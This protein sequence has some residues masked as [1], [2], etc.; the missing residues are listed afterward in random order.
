M[1]SKPFTVVDLVHFVPFFILLSARAK[2]Y[3]LPRELKLN[4]IRQQ[5]IA[6][7]AY[8]FPKEN[9]ILSFL[10][11]VYAL[12]AYLNFIRTYDKDVELKIWLRMVCAA[13]LVFALACAIFFICIS[14]SLSSE[15]QE[16][17][18]IFIMA[19]FIALVSYFVFAQP[20]I[21]N[22]RSIS[23]MIP[24]VKYEKTGLT[25]HFSLELKQKLQNIMEIEKPYLDPDVRLDTIAELMDVSRH[26]A[27]QVINEHFSTHFFDFINQYRIREAERL[28]AIEKS[29]QS[30][31]NIAYSSGFNN[32]ISFYKAFKKMVGTTPSEYR[33]D[34]LTS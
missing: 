20:D 16:S 10:L 25:E 5:E 26:H 9:I 32:R 13:F 19:I 3:A 22:G 34:C 17:Y 14:L 15:I 2:F 31:K 24:F 8:F 4:V 18:L 1:T 11:L 29:K 21:F 12:A 28:L 30:I 23:E 6:E 33:K 27:S 7:Y